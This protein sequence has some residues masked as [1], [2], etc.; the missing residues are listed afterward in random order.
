VRILLVPNTTNA[1]SVDA[2]VQAAAWLTIQGYEPILVSEDAGAC[3]L[4][5]YGVSRSE[6]GEPQLVV[7]LGGDGT[8]LKTVHTLGD[9]DVPIMGVNLGRLGFLSGADGD[10]LIEA[11]T[12]ALAGEVKVERR[13]LLQTHI[14]IGGRRAGTYRALNE[15]F[16]GR[17]GGSRTVELEVTVN[18]TRVG[19]YLADGVIIATPTGSTAYALSAGGPVVAPDVRGMVLVPVAPHTMSA[20]PMVLSPSD[21][22][23]ITCPNPQRGDACVTIDGDQ[24]PCRRMLD[25]VSVSLSDHEVSLLR[26]NG[27]DF[28][29]VL[30][31]TFIR[32]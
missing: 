19:R 14:D 17:G 13:Q 20:R 6:L 18:G 9:L 11:L 23:E 22:V 15:V 2:A 28:Y 4:G 7:S 1:R 12:A 24:V 3:G 27:R 8:I 10:H 31:E 26:M 32:D 21:H 16:V 29:D 25:S 30:S 5:S